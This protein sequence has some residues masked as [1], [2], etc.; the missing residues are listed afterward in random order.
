MLAR[1][2][3][4]GA[5]TREAAASAPPGGT[6]E[7]AAKAT[8]GLAAAAP[9]AVVRPAKASTFGPRRV[10]AL[11]AIIGQADPAAPIA[12]SRTPILAA[13]PLVP[14]GR[15]RNAAAQEVVEQIAHQ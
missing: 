1:A 11:P 8:L 12:G 15:R 13:L 3:R 2:A 4:S 5:G 10:G 7:T 9:E 6:S 14:I